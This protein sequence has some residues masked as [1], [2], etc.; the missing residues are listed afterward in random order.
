MEVVLKIS[1]FILS[2]VDI[3]FIK[4]KL[5]WRSYTTKKALPTTCRVE[6]INKKKFTK[7]ALDENIKVFIIY[8]SFLSLKSKIMIYPAQKT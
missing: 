1:F 3:Q 7:T 5:T 4:K 8:M 2:N 6:H